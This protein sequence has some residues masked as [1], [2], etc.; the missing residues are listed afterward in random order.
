MRDR[1]TFHA[2]LNSFSQS[3]GNANSLRDPDC[4]M[5]PATHDEDYTAVAN[6]RMRCERGVIRLVRFESRVR[7]VFHPDLERRF[8]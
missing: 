3:A 1:V 8:P 7:N 4:S 5:L 2:G 6:H